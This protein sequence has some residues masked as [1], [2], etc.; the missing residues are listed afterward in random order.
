[1][2]SSGS[3]GKIVR[4]NKR[5]QYKAI[6]DSFRVFQIREIDHK[7]GNSQQKV[8]KD[9]DSK[10]ILG[11]LEETA[12]TVV[13]KSQELHKNE[14]LLGTNCPPQNKFKNGVKETAINP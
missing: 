10:Q 3:I 7:Y 6:Q 8:F 14:D 5:D 13:N 1:M 9:F 4:N 12:S 2:K 11:K